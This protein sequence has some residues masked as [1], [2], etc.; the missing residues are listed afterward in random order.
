ML[1]PNSCLTSVEYF[2]SRPNSLTSVEYFGS[3]RNFLISLELNLLLWGF[4]F[5]TCLIS[6]LSSQNSLLKNTSELWCGINLWFDLF[7]KWVQR[8]HQNSLEYLPMF[9]IFMTVGGIKHPIIAAVLGCVYVVARF[10]YFKGYSTG[11]P[12]NRLTFGY[13]L[14]T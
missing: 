4:I 8:G 9:F 3:R 11:E 1:Q 6:W 2:G 10:F 7:W 5:L 12:K 13:V 14:S